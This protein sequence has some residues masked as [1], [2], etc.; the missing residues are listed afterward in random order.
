MPPR[1]IESRAER[2]TR[3]T[4]WCRP[5]PHA[6]C[7]T[8]RAPGAAHKYLLRGHRLPQR[9]RDLPRL[10]GAHHSQGSSHRCHAQRG[11]RCGGARDD[12]GVPA[13][14][15]AEGMQCVAAEYMTL[16]TL[17]E[18]GRSGGV[19]RGVGIE[20][21]RAS[22]HTDQRGVWSAPS[23]AAPRRSKRTGRRGRLS[24]T[25]QWSLLGRRW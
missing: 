24:Q 3:L 22:V 9:S 15:E 16:A 11:G 23:I 6:R 19:A 8:S 5:P 20:R 12:P 1:L 2:S 17:A 21:G 7:S 25:G 10:G 13:L 18:A 4:L 14:E